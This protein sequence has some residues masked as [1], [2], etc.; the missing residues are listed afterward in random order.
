MNNPNTAGLISLASLIVDYENGDLDDEQV[1]KFFQR[2]VDTGLAWSLQGSY[3][4]AA[5]RL[6]DRGLIQSGG[7]DG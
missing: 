4:R 7:R 6:L 5:A 1:I 2:L 3:G